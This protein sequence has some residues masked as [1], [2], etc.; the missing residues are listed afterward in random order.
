MAEGG[1]LAQD[2]VDLTRQSEHQGHSGG[3]GLNTDSR[4]GRVALE[5]EVDFGSV[6]LAKK[7]RASMD[8]KTL[9]YVVEFQGA[10]QM[11]MQK[12]MQV[13]CCKGK[14]GEV[15]GFREE[16]MDGDG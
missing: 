16:E 8:D 3:G 13:Q 2:E 6:G 10:D 11:Q 15:S 14:R 4:G 9:R 5:M 7:E 12:E 1:R